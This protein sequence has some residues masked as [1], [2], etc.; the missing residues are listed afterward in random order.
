[1]KKFKKFKIKK[2]KYLT[3][4]TVAR[5]AEKKKGFDFVEKISKE[6]INKIK[7]RWIIIGRNIK[8]LNSNKFI[9]QHRSFLS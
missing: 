2:S 6:L 9:S 8:K 1:M 4:I 7:F 3:L 5:Y